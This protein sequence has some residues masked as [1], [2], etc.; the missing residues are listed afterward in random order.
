M[1]PGD[2]SPPQR[3]HSPPRPPAFSVAAK[4]DLISLADIV[5]SDAA[6]SG[7]P[8]ADPA[9]CSLRL[10]AGILPS[11]VWEP[12]GWAGPGPV[13]RWVTGRVEGPSIARRAPPGTPGSPGGCGQCRLPKG[14]G[15]RSCPPSI[16]PGRAD[17]TDPRRPT[18]A[19]LAP[20]PPAEGARTRAL[21]DTCAAG[22]RRDC[23]VGNAQAELICWFK[24]PLS[25]CSSSVPPAALLLQVPDPAMPPAAGRR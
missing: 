19:L 6:P 1:R 12:G 24:K 4:W 15:C 17:T 11:G 7:L 14:R 2:Q 21:S 22:P 3:S 8:A 20:P 16:V 13:V 5:G 25:T 23:P 18:E 9:P 10:G